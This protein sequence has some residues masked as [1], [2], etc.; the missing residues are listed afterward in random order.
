MNNKNI[1]SVFLIIGTTIGAGMLSLPLIVAS[2][3]FFVSI[4]LLIVSW[5]VMY[6]T[7][8]RLLNAC[9]KYPIGANFTTMLENKT[10]KL[11]QIFFGIIYLLLL[12]SLMAAYTTQ[13]ASLV[14]SIGHLSENSRSNLFATTINA[15]IFILIFSSLM[16]S[17]KVS[18]YANRTF[19]F[20]KL[21]FFIL[22]LLLMVI[23]LNLN[24]ILSQ[25]LSFIALVFAWPT[26]L[27]SFGFQNIIP[28]LYE[29]Q[30]GNVKE[31]KKSI[32][33]GS[34]CV[35]AIYFIWVFLCLGII[36]Q[37]SYHTIFTKGN[38][39]GDFIS[40]VKNITNSSTIELLLNIFIN[41]AIITSFLCVGISLMHYIKDIFSKFNKNINYITICLLTFVIPFIF[42]IFYP[43]GFILALQYAAIFAVIIFVFTPLILDK[44]N[45]I[46]VEG[47]YACILGILV[48]ISQIYIL[49]FTVNPF[50]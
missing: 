2:C 12:F 31:I 41:I 34:L 10:P 36:P 7:S 48:I 24:N 33:I 45:K 37:S 23:Y 9:D 40:Q 39:L 3:G 26:L 43:K 38:S 32:L 44:K 42:T 46:T 22:C 8:L 47:T 6:L 16:Y 35:L 29:Y 28:V 50:I 14:G 49:L 20:L 17:Y 27:P 21:I 25:P 18:D 1:G 30:N 13:G 11:F 19:V 5:S 15:F 4:L